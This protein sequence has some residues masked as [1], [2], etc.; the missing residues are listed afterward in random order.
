MPYPSTA[1]PTTTLPESA[2]E[3]MVAV[4]EPRQH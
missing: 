4:G 1:P 2:D 3:H